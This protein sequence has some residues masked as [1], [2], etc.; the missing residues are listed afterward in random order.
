MRTLFRLYQQ[1]IKPNEV[2][3]HWLQNP[4][5]LIVKLLMVF[6]QDHNMKRV[7]ILKTVLKQQTHEVWHHFLILQNSIM[8][9]TSLLFYVCTELEARLEEKKPL[10]KPPDHLF[11]LKLQV[12]KELS[13]KPSS[14]H[15][16]LAS[17]RKKNKTQITL[18]CV[19]KQLLCY[20]GKDSEN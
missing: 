16:T 15:F 11:F 19:P 5:L 8:Q 3:L 9:C 10:R 17:Q 1:S 7:Y 4:Y 2:I 14:A 18:S 6:Y 12:T 20:R 13:T